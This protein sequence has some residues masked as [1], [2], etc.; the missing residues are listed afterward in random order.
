[1]STLLFIMVNANIPI[2][3]VRVSIANSLAIWAKIFVFARSA[4]AILEK[5]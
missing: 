1:M 3:Q 4:E 5:V 2:V